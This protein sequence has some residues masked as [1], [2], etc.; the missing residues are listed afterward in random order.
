MVGA[1]MNLSSRGGGGEGGGDAVQLKGT[2]A[3]NK[4]IQ[5]SHTSA[6]SLPEGPYKVLFL[7]GG[8]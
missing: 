1:T 5:T 3:K 2:S 6:P 4:T 8:H 7:V